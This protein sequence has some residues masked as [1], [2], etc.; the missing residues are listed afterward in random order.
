MRILEK[1]PAKIN[2]SLDV[3]SK[4]PDG[5]HE[6]EMIMTTIDL[7][8]RI[9]LTELPEN[10]IRV[11]SHNR[12]V[13]DDQRNL[14]Y[15]AAKLLKERFQVKKGVSIMITKV[16]PVAAGLAGGSSDAAATLRGLNRLWDLK[17]SVEE[18]AELGAEIG[19]DVSFCV[20][21]GT[22]L[23]TGRGEKIRHISAPPHCWVVLAKP[24][25]GVSTAEV[26]RRLNLQQVRHPDVQAMID[27]IEEK[28]FQKVCGQ[29]GNV[30]ES[31][32][33]SLHPEVA[34]IKNQMKRFGADAVLMSGSGPTVFGLVQ[35]ESKVQRIY[36]G[37]RGFCDQVYAVRMIGEQNALD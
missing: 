24:T 15:Q 31:V 25:I 21:G 28:S 19:S 33:L 11:A 26:Y 3:T 34:M 1:A 20:Y 9:E 32:T 13:P 18:L 7:S 5:Y 30:L 14:A 10:V 36:N 37:L 22:A 6:V 12:F 4:R 16:I 29:L 35:Y 23:A 2:L 27:A 8:D 17:L